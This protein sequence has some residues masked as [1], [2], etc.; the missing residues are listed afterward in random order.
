MLRE[1]LE[2]EKDVLRQVTLAREAIR[3][4]YRAIKSGKETVA[5]EFTTLF[6]P[7]IA[8]L[9]KLS[10]GKQEQPA[11]GKQEASEAENILKRLRSSFP[12]KELDASVF[13]VRET[14][15]G[16]HMIGNAVIR[17]G[18]NDIHVGE[19]TYPRTQGLSELILKKSPNEN[20]ITAEDRE[21][22]RDILTSSNAHRT[23]YSDSGVI[24]GNRSL[25]Y[26]RFI[27]R[28]VSG[29][30]LPESMLLNPSFKKEYIYYDDV[31]ELVQRLKLLAAAYQAGNHSVNNE[32]V[33]ILEE[34][35]EADLIY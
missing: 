15:G 4:K 27:G 35:R 3:R 19:K 7:V 24:R 6:Q 16:S 29:Q 21:H 20:L 28:L 13:G 8:P 11:Q 18:T 30:G 17:F 34:L 14:A 26:T 12:K 2:R 31:N 10:E 5:R 33:S 22:Y 23:G 25:K 9:E 1:D 32:I